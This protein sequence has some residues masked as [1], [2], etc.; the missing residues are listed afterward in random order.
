MKRHGTDVRI[1][2][3]GIFKITTINILRV[4]MDS[5]KEQMDKIRGEMEILR[6]PQR[7]ARDKIIVTEMKNAFDGFLS[8]PC[9]AEE[10][11]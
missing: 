2:R 3:L 6:E 8:I 4:L 9:S 7:N 5:M 11:R 1:I 10:R